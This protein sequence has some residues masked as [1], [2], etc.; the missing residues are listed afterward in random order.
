MDVTS[1]KIRRRFAT[2][3]DVALP[4]PVKGQATRPSLPRRRNRARR[5]S[6]RHRAGVPVGQRDDAVAQAGV[7]IRPAVATNRLLPNRTQCWPRMKR[8]LA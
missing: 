7:R 2:S 1:V 5:S 4:R 3:Q 8:V 6:R